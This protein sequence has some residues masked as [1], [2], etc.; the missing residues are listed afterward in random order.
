MLHM[1]RNLQVERLTL[2]AISLGIARRSL[3]IM[4]KYAGERAKPLAIRSATSAKFSTMI[5]E[6]YAEYRAARTYV[7]NTARL[8]KLDSHGHRLDSDGVKLIAA[9]IGKKNRRPCDSGLGR[10]RLRRRICR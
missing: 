4:V 10:L 7:Y 9:P 2:A 1:M 8:M 3:E 6:S 5:A